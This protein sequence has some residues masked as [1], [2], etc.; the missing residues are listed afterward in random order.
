MSAAYCSLFWL[1]P[2]P[3][4][5]I[6]RGHP[7]TQG[8]SGCLLTEA[9]AQDLWGETHCEPGE[10]SAAAQWRVGQYLPNQCQAEASTHNPPV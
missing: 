2:P 9:P 3:S 7:A 1:L 10:K 4:P 6:G 5:S 8:L